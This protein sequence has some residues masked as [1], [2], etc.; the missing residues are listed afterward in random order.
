M[1]L[2]RSHRL[3]HVINKCEGR[4]QYNTNSICSTCTYHVSQIYVVCGHEISI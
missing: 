2:S 3:I 4:G 1:D